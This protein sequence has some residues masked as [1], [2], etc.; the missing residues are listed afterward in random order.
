MPNIDM[1]AVTAAAQAGYVEDITKELTKK[2]KVVAKRQSQVN[3]FVAY[4]SK[5]VKDFN[6]AVA[7]TTEPAEVSAVLEA[8]KFP[9]SSIC[10]NP[11]QD[12]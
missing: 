4:F 12:D 1:T 2:L 5:R 9:A 7:A 8:H 11:R 10:F 6:D 3:S